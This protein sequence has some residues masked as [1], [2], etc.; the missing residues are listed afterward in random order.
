MKNRIIAFILAIITLLALVSCGDDGKKNSDGKTEVV[1][2]SKFQAADGELVDVSSA[3]FA[4][5]LYDYVGQYSQYLMWYGYDVS[6]PL[7]KQ[8]SKCAFDETKTWFEYFAEMTKTTVSQCLAFAS[9]AIEA[10][11]SLSEED[12]KDLD[13]YMKRTEE[14]AYK[15]GFDGIDGLIA[16]YYCAGISA[17]EFRACMELQQLAYLYVEKV[18]DDID[19]AEYPTEELLSFVER[20]KDSFYGIDYVHYSFFSDASSTATEEEKQASYAA[21][22]A[23]AE[24]LVSSCADL[25]AFKAEIVKLDNEGLEKPREPE[26]ILK[27]YT[28]IHE[29]Y[30]APSTETDSSKAYYEWAYSSDRKAGDTYIYEQ[31]LSAGSKYYTVIYLTKPAYLNDAITKDVRHIFFEVKSTLTGDELKAEEEKILAKAQEVLNTYKASEMTEEAF[32]ALA[33]QHSQDS[34]AAQGGIYEHVER[35]QMVDEFDNWIFDESRNVGDAEII[36]TPYGYHIMYF[37]GEGYDV[38]EYKALDMLK[39]ELYSNNTDE[40][41]KKYP[42]TFNEDAIKQIP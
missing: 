5:F 23:K 14:E 41:V 26:A 4:F 29:T 32:A 22:K 18:L 30:K 25:E 1:D 42:I 38:W 27:D 11:M 7:S 2:L 13:E 12:L 15:Q 17:A 10:G 6:L 39:D 36:R 19:S 8:T 16:N 31:T 21:A 28:A 35:G 33:V 24:A 37:V 34:N 40:L 3:I 9:A 20:N